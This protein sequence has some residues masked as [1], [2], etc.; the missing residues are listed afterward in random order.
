VN[1]ETQKQTVLKI[2]L[3]SGVACI[4]WMFL[5][6]PAFR[7]VKDQR[8]T[9]KAHELLI[10]TYKEKIGEIDSDDSL[11]V[12][13]RLEGI[14]ASMSAVMSEGDSGTALHGLI[15]EVAGRNGISMARIESIKESKLK[16][17]VESSKSEVTGINHQVRIE[18][19]G[20]FG[21]VMRFM[22]EI[23]AAQ[24]PVKFSN[25]RFIPTGAESVRV[26]AEINSVMLTSIPIDHDQ[27][28]M[29]NE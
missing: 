12:Q 25:F 6:Q 13:E 23:A 20:D 24:I 2:L 22:D 3:V 15:N 27:G 10:S 14:L 4:A 17:E 8:D 21:S 18:F 7:G 9:V 19:E 5:V 26:N 11:V 16:Q 29:S 1:Q 28:G